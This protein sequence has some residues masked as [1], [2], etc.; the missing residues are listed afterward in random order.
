MCELTRLEPLHTGL[1]GAD[2][3][4]LPAGVPVPDGEAE[5][6]LPVTVGQ[7]RKAHLLLNPAR[8][9]RVLDHL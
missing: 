7:R 9:Q 3:V 2:E 6:T 1:K 5:T 4:R 8:V